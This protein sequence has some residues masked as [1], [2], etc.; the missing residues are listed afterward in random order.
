MPLK[1]AVLPLLDSSDDVVRRSGAAN[2]VVLAEGRRVGANTDVPG[3]AWALA[4][5]VP[6]AASAPVTVLGAGATARSAVLSLAAVGVR[7]ATV[8]ARRPEATTAL[9]DVASS[10]GVEL[11]V[12]PWVDAAAA[13][14]AGLV[15]ST[16]PSGA[17]DSLAERLPD[18]PVTLVD[19]VYAPWPTPLASAWS[20]AGGSVV[21]GLEMLVRQAA[22][23]L[24]LM[25][26]VDVDLA[27]VVAVMRSAG[28]AELARRGG[29]TG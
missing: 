8:V 22:L 27:Q 13:L 25:T 3:L 23:Q 19:V 10:A 26:G 15:V 28:A 6:R 29:R 5:L 1:S 18:G 21:G 24:R 2:T 16:V 17:A 20:A 9:A 12:R 11:S 7:A 14:A 4:D